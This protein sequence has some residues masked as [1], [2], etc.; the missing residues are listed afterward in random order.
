MMGAAHD[1]I[2]NRRIHRVYLIALPLFI[3]GQIAI[4]Q[5]T[6]TEWWKSFAHAILF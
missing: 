4:S 6:F 5:I 1:L 3:V 2:V